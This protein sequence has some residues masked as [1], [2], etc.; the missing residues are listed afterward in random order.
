MLCVCQVSSVCIKCS[1]MY[2]SEKSH[3]DKIRNHVQKRNLEAAEMMKNKFNNA[4]RTKI[5]KFEVG[6]GVTVRVPSEDRGPCDQQ[7]VPRVIVKIS[8]NTHKIRTQYGIL[9]FQY[10]TDE[11]ERHAI[12]VVSTDGWEDDAVISL[13]EAARRYNHR[14]DDVAVCKCKSGCNSK[15]CRCFKENLVCTSRCHNGTNCHNKGIQL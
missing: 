15:K 14:R 11:L 12:K 1:Y 7:R 6:D 5:E 3:H 2:Y 4:K 9:K 10:C 13:R 8:N